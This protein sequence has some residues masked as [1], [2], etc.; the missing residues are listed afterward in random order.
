MRTDTVLPRQSIVV[1]RLDDVLARL[2]LVVR[3]DRVLEIEEDHVDRALGRLL[4]QLHPAAGNGQFAAVEAAGACRISWKLMDSSRRMLRCC[5][6][7]VAP[8]LANPP[9]LSTRRRRQLGLVRPR[10]A[11]GAGLTSDLQAS[12]PA[13]GCRSASSRCRRGPAS[14]ARRADRRRRPADGWRRRGAARAA[15]RAPDR[16]RRSSA[17]SFSSLGEALAG[18]MAFG[19]AARG[20]EEALRLARFSCSALAHPRQAAIAVARRL[21]QRHQAFL[22]ALAAH[23]QHLRIAL[24]GRQRQASPAPTRACRWRRAVSSSAAPRNPARP[25]IGPPPRSAHRLPRCV[26]ILGS[27]RARRGRVERRGGIVA[28]HAL[29]EQEAIELAQGREP[30]RGGAGG[31]AAAGRSRQKGAQI[32]R[33]R[34]R[35]ARRRASGESRSACR[36]RGRRNRCVLRAAPRSA[37]IISRKISTCAGRG[38][39][40]SRRRPRVAIAALE[41]VRQR[42]F[43]GEAAGDV[44]QPDLAQRLHDGA[45]ASPA[46]AR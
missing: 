2:R 24:D 16:G 32:V 43:D 12:R 21:A 42:H 39:C 35:P 6:C 46:T 36:D 15:T 22:V 26:S 29:G 31:K 3:R 33:R 30:A 7:E 9:A 44:R 37:V 40:S 4:E 25:A 10:P 5:N 19:G 8:V 45:Q 28:A 1:Q 20:K 11:D 18:E 34:V 27:G 23:D 41:R 14:S 13:R 17:S 38:G